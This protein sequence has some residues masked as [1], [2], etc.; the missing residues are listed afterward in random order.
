V[1][2]LAILFALLC[3]TAASARAAQAISHGGNYFGDVIVEPGQTVDGDI[4]VI[5]GNVTVEGTVDG[6]INVVGGSIYERPGAVVTGQENA[7]G[8]EVVRSIVPWMPSPEIRSPY[9]PDMHVLWR[10]AWDAV[11]LLVFLIFPVRTRMALDRLELHPGLCAAVGTLAWVAVIPLAL[12]LVVSII[13]IP[14]VPL[15]AVAVAAGSC[16]G[17]AAL[18]LLVGRRLYELLNPSR[19]AAPFAALLIGLALLTSAEL[20]PVLGAL[21][22]ILV[23][24]VGLGA[25]IL[26]LFAEHGFTG[27]ARGGP[28]MTA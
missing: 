7:L 26:S 21:V 5:A 18:A 22:T 8:G 12:L 16:I 4:N 24:L 25:S 28:P 15:E 14:L 27:L 20:V 17:T 6:D 19:T 1:K 9:Q 2:T 13:L 3:V 23:L 11:V 10:I